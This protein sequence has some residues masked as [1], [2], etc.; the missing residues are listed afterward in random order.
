MAT[1]THTA[2]PITIDLRKYKVIKKNSIKIFW[3]NIISEILYKHIQKLYSY[4]EEVSF[5]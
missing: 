3:S 2:R 1:T 5:F 4:N